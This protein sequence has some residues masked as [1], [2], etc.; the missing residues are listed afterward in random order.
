MSSLTGF[1]FLHMFITTVHGLVPPSP[2]LAISVPSSSTS[3]T[4]DLLNL[5]SSANNLQLVNTT[6]NENIKCDGK[7]WGYH[8]NKASCEEAWNQMPTDN[9]FVSFGARRMGHFE[10][11]LPYRYLSDDGLC[12]I[13]IDHMIKVV[14]DTATNHEISAAAKSILDKCV[15]RDEPKKQGNTPIG[16]YRNYI[17]RKKGLGISVSSYSPHVKC[18]LDSELEDETICTKLLGTMPI[19]RS[20]YVFIREKTS[21]AKKRDYSVGWQE[22][23]KR[24]VHCNHR[25]RGGGHG[26]EL[27]VRDVDGSCGCQ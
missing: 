11:P 5:S 13:D 7:Y 27:L 14:L 18:T 21:W 17:G 23:I 10:R 22:N 3:S 9:Q 12:A 2:N 16:G 20:S 8:L 24:N 1:V 6:A 25:L 19:N 26:Q 15:L 4:L